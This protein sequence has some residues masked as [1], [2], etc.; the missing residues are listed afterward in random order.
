MEI[1]D[2]IDEI[3]S[4]PYLLTTYQVNDCVLRRYPQTNIGT[5]NPHKNGFGWRGP[6]QVTQVNNRTGGNLVDKTY[7]TIRNLVTDK[8]YVVDVRKMCPFYFEPN[9]VT[10]LNVAVKDTDKT[11]VDATIFQISRIK[12]GW[13]AGYAFHHPSPGNVTIILK[14][15]RHFINTAQR[16]GWIHSFRSKTQHFLSQCRI[17]TDGQLSDS[18]TYY[19]VRKSE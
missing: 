1:I 2:T 3:A 19:D 9:Y 12:S 13:V 8:E 17:C 11:V 14:T 10:P 16:T 7:Y 15:W 4:N 18:L 5:G 6:F